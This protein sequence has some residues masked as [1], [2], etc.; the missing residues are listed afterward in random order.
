MDI[1]F[2]APS[3]SHQSSSLQHEYVQQ[4]DVCSSKLYQEKHFLMSKTK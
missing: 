2:N 4:N 1:V 3:L